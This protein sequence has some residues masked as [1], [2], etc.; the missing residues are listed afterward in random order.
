MLDEVLFRESI[1][2][3]KQGLDAATLRQKVIADNIANV[4]TP[5]YQGRRVQFEE[6]LRGRQAPHRLGLAAPESG[7]AAGLVPGAAVVTPRVEVDTSP[8]LRSGINNVDVEREMAGLQ[9]NSLVHA[10]MTQLISAK[11]KMIRQ[12]IVDR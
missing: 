10:A 4:A 2:A 12:A 7:G 11:Y 3:L 1:P 8:A 9:R 6:L 5:G